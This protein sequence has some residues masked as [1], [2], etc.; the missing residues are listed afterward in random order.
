MLTQPGPE[1]LFLFDANWARHWVTE[2]PTH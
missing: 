1:Q 2:L